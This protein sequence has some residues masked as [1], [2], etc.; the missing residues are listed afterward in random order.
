MA[1]NLEYSLSSDLLC[2]IWIKHTFY[3]NAKYKN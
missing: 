3:E 1:V 2:G